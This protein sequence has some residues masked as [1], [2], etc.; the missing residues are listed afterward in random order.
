M[1]IACTLFNAGIIIEAFIK[2]G[3]PS[4]PVGGTSGPESIHHR[5]HGLFR[6]LAAGELCLANDKLNLNAE[7]LVLTRNYEAFLKK[8][9]HLATKPAIKFHIGDVRDFEFPTG[10]FPFVIH[11][12]TGWCLRCSDL[13]QLWSYV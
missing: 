6:L 13:A 8:A 4:R 9:N 5:R 7:A 10:K 1:R 3:Y 11:S 2:S 12:A